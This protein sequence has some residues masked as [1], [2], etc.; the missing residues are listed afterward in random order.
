MVLLHQ[1]VD[2]P[3]LCLLKRGR[4]GERVIEISKTISDNR[5]LIFGNDARGHSKKSNF[6]IFQW[7]SVSGF[8]QQG[9]K[10]L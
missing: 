3:Y 5:I 4:G 2:M 1:H 10:D 7:M 9:S 8:S 6:W